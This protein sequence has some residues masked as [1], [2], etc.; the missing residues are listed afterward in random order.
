MLITLL[1]AGCAARHAPPPRSAE[2]PPRFVSAPV[3]QTAPAARTIEKQVPDPCVSESQ[4][5]DEPRLIADKLTGIAKYDV[6]PLEQSAR[7]LRD[8][9]RK[10]RALLL[11]CAKGDADN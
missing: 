8:A 7:A 2:P 11:K 10:A 3:V 5:P 1:L 9:L 4:I 6:G